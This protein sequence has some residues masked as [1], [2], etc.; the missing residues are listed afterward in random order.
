MRITQWAI[1]DLGDQPPP[2]FYNGRICIIGDAAHATSPHHG[3]GAGFCIEDSAIL[4]EL[5]T[6]EIVKG[7]RH[8][9]AVFAT[10]D[11]VRRERCRWLVESSRWI[12]DC[13]EWRAEGVGRD[14]GKI[15]REINRRMDII[16]GIDID[17]VNKEARGVLRR[18]IG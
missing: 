9:E 6:D 4:A 5:L 15:E 11:G 8:L 18:N 10:F 16:S 7:Q 12:G 14:F 13:Y 2:T 3:A 17:E 1:F